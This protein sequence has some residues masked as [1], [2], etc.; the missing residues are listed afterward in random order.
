MSFL[1]DN[2]AFEAWLRHQCEVYEPDLD[3][4]HK[5]MKRDPFTFLRATYFR[6]AKGIEDVCPQLQYAPAVLSVGDIHLENFGTWRDSEGRLVW[7]V[8]DFD[9]AAVIPY[10]YDLVRL[11]TSVRLARD[12]KDAEESG[13][14]PFLKL[15]N[16]DT[17]AMLLTGYRDGLNKPRPTLMDEHATE[18]RPYFACSDANRAQFWSK[19]EE[20]K[21]ESP[22]EAVMA[23]FKQVLPP[24]ASI[25]RTARRPKRGC[26]SLGRPRWVVV[27]DWCGGRI[28][29]EA[30]ALIPSAWEWAHGNE[31]APLR[32]KDL[33]CGPHRSF[34]PTLD[35]INRNIF[36]RLAADA[37]K[38]NL[39]QQTDINAP[40]ADEAIVRKLLHAM[41]F[42]LGTIHAADDKQAKAILLDLDQRDPSWLRE[43][44]KAAARWVSEDYTEWCK[45]S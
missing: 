37:R 6:W 39:A 8:N 23:G 40:E 43:A 33:A 29:R 1:Q 35:L 18:L 15:S 27:A 41:S 32:F 11:A 9:E 14:A 45:Q 7:G 21:T 5:R 10:A 26:G 16:R 22:G 3:Y 31:A 28:V 44:A 25:I 36:R 34:D 13:L 12:S 20:L 4:K 30:K 38:V 24:K 2:L 42:D 17:A 19:I